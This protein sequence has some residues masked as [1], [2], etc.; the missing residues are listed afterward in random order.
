MSTLQGNFKGELKKL[1]K[2]ANDSNNGRD[3]PTQSCPKPQ[4]PSGFHKKTYSARTFQP[5]KKL[6]DGIEDDERIDY[7]LRMKHNMTDHFDNTVHANPYGMTAHD[8]KSVSLSHRECLEEYKMK[9]RRENYMYLSQH[10]EIDAMIELL[11]RKL[12]T[13]LPC[14]PVRAIAEF[15]CL[16]TS[17][18][19]EHKKKIDQEREK[20]VRYRKAKSK[21]FFL[22]KP[23]PV[24]NIRKLNLGPLADI[25]EFSKPLEDEPEPEL[26][27]TAA[28]IFDLMAETGTGNYQDEYEG[29]GYDENN[30]QPDYNQMQGTWSEFPQNTAAYGEETDADGN[31]LNADYD[32]TGWTGGY[33]DTETSNQWVPQDNYVEFNP[34]EAPMGDENE[35]PVPDI[36]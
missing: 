20:I 26:P 30:Y 11:L 8:Y 13:E 18:Y 25:L 27:P 34:T 24:A 21:E 17:T 3:V 19:D 6:C 4:V 15:F 9:T 10:P 23:E 7:L 22:P 32:T 16:K 14:D 2:A 36:Y 31:F 12:M 33:T 5:S 1:A 28:P 29:E 35:N